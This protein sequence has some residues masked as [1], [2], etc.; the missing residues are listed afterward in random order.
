VGAAGMQGSRKTPNAAGPLPAGTTST[1]IPGAPIA[2]RGTPI[3]AAAAARMTPHQMES[4]RAPRPPTSLR[5][6]V[7]A[8]LASALVV[9]SVTLF[10]A[11]A[12]AK[13][14]P[15]VCAAP[16]VT[17]ASLALATEPPGAQIFIDGDPS[18]M[19]TPYTLTGL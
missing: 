10:I 5:R 19:T 1:S 12:R 8:G 13:V 2:A 3:G 18:G 14:E 15:P 7:L 6:Q 9:M 17:T 4:S 16:V 11:R